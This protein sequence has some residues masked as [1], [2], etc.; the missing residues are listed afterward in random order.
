MSKSG[1]RAYSSDDRV[2][3]GDRRAKTASKPADRKEGCTCGCK[4][5]K[6]VEALLEMMKKA[7]ERAGKAPPP[8]DPD[9]GGGDPAPGIGDAPPE[10]A[11][12]AEWIAK[13]LAQ[14]EGSIAER[15]QALRALIRADKDG[16]CTGPLIDLLAENKKNVD[17]LRADLGVHSE[18]PRWHHVGAVVKERRRDNRPPP[19][20]PGT[21]RCRVLAD[22]SGVQGVGHVDD[23]H[24][25]PFGHVGQSLP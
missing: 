17:L 9:A 23:L 12:R 14:L 4:G 2:R 11:A 7:E 1:R 24:S 6:A 5:E 20:S 22:Q 16:D 3:E 21:V 25:A 18:D 8:E 13:M 15:D 19:T 10:G